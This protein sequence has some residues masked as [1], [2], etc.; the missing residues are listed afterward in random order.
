MVGK[1]GASRRG[2]GVRG[3]LQCEVVFGGERAV[4]FAEVASSLPLFHRFVAGAVVGCG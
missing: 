4:G 1:S 2:R 3:V